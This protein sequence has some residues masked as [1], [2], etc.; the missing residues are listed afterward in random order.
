MNEKTQFTPTRAWIV[1]IAL[2][3]GSTLIAISGQSGLVPA[4]AILVLAWGK[5]RVILRQY[6]GLAQAPGWSRGFSLVLA[7]YMIVA[8]GLTV[9]SGG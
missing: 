9:A 3:M 7:I 2:S 8:M 1:L 6:L 4:L 5:A